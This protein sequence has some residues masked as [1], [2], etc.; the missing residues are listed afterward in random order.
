[1]HQT[2]P[3]YSRS[4]IWCARRD[5]NYPGYYSLGVSNTTKHYILWISAHLIAIQYLEIPPVF[6][7]IREKIRENFFFFF[8]RISLF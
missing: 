2:F 8:T 6:T 1:M 4:S 3:M 7:L 5:L